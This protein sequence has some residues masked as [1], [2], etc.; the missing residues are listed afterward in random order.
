VAAATLACCAVHANVLA[1][2]AGVAVGLWAVTAV[3]VALVAA[4]TARTRSR[5][6]VY[7]N[8]R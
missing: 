2:L 1:S 6:S 4:V 7:A 5:G 3:M 8:D